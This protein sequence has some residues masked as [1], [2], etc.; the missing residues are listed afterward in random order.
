MVVGELKLCAIG[1]PPLECNRESA[2]AFRLQRGQYWRELY[3]QDTESVC[4]WKPRH[5]RGM[6]VR[7]AR[8]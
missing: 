4:G 8:W 6:V 2:G 1:Q 5:N 3:G 7:L